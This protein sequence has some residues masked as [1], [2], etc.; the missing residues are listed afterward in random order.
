M[1]RHELVPMLRL[2]GPVVLAEIGWVAMG[3]VDTL[4]VGRI[5]PAAIGAVGI[6]SSLF[7]AIAIFGMGLLLGLDTL[8]SHAY[9]A[10]RLDEC[11]RWLRDGLMLGA[12]A[13]APLGVLEWACVTLLPR[14]GISGD[15]LALTVPYLSIVA[16]SLP[17]LLAYAAFRRYLQAVNLVKPVMFALVSANLV[18][19]G[20]NWILIFG[21]LG[22]PALGVRG[23]AW[24]TLLSR[25]YMAA[26]LGLVAWRHQRE[27]RGPQPERA[28]WRPDRK[29]LARLVELGL[30]AA[31]QVTLEVGVFATVSALAGRLNAAS[32]AA[33]QV[34]LHMASFTFMVPLGLASAG[35]VRV[36]H[37]VGR[38]DMHAAQRSGW[39]ALALGVGFMSCA[40]LVFLGLPGPLLRAFTADTGVIVTGTGLLAIAAAFQPFDGLQGVAT[41]TLRG[42]GDTRTPMLANVVAHWLIGLPAGYLLCF[43]AGWGISGLWVG[44]ALG[45]ISVGATL[46]AKW[47]HD[48][49][50]AIVRADGS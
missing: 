27:H 3:I 5:G 28:A 23:A 37:A 32:L 41:G 24:A 46:A 4:M 1:L 7:L 33:H 50:A 43:V 42:L 31:A 48:S 8:V 45:L 16:W 21:H 11:R 47:H 17:P 39:M 18:N 22:A 34:V 15:V 38:R 30:P 12:L 20:V 29:R 25:V 6:G 44:F 40:S 49:R 10:G 36:G 9:G 13:A 26:L 19:A 2:A 35:A 14:W